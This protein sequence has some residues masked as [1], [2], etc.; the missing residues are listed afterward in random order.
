MTERE[1]GYLLAAL[2]R[3]IARREK[4]YERTAERRAA[5]FARHP[6]RHDGDRLRIEEM[7]AVRGRLAAVLDAEIVLVEIPELVASAFLAA[8]EDEC[9]DIDEVEAVAELIER[10]KIE[11]AAATRV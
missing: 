7:E 4:E 10:S 11:G 9:D 5:Y 6:D 1:I 3:E 2:D 8:I